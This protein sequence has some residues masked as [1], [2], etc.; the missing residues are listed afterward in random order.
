MLFRSFDITTIERVG[1]SMVLHLDDNSEVT[2][3]VHH[4]KELVQDIVQHNPRI[5][6]QEK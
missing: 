4:A 3:R 2:M 6:L 5:E 1:R